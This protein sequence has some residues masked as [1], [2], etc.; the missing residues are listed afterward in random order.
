MSCYFRHLQDIFREAGIQVTPAKEHYRIR[1]HYI[2]NLPSRRVQYFLT[3]SHI[4]L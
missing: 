4:P 3:S 1:Y 2:L